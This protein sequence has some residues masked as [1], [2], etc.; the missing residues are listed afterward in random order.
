MKPL[1]QK[2]LLAFI[3]HYVAHTVRFL[4][5]FSGV[6]EEKIAVIE[7]QMQ[8]LETTMSILEGKVRFSLCTT[9]STTI[10]GSYG[11]VRLSDS[12]S[13]NSCNGDL[14]ICYFKIDVSS[15]LLILQL[16]SIPGLD[17]VTVTDAPPAQSAA[18]PVD[19]APAA[20]PG[21]ESNTTVQAS[22]EQTASEQPLPAAVS[23]I[24]YISDILCSFIN[25]GL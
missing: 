17:G 8:R 1:D 24:C 2:R 22:T 7:S 19:S 18:A 14:K 4:N 9:I 25:L 13:V 10:I 21:G 15:L 23:T 11:F 5:R 12:R 6:C 20:A 16:S 3:N